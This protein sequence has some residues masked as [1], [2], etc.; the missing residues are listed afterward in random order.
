MRRRTPRLDKRGKRDY[1]ERHLSNELH[2]LLRS[3]TEWHIQDQLRLGIDG[4]HVQ[5]YAMDS[6]CLHARALFEFFVNRTTHNHYGYDQFLGGD[7]LKSERYENWKGAL[8]GFLMHAQDRSSP[9][10]LK[11]LEGDKD[12]NQMPVDFAREVLRLWEAFE[13]RLSQSGNSDDQELKQLAR[14]KRKEAIEGAERVANSAV[15]QMHARWK[16]QTLHPVFSF[17]G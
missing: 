4:Y 12:L 11:S 6:A 2:W 3:A 17:A 14:S 16:A 1:V 7:P 5:V 8:H 13:A 10:P 15:A 9:V